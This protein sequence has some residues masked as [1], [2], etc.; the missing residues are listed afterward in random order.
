[1]NN[2]QIYGLLLAIIFSILFHLIVIKSFSFKIFRSDQE[3]FDDMEI[4]IVNQINL[5]SPKTKESLTNNKK[6]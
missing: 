2:F 4:T 1:M 5:A 3:T 6:Y